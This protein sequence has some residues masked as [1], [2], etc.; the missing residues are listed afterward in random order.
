MFTFRYL[1]T[2]RC[3]HLLLNKTNLPSNQNM[4][5]A[6]RNNKVKLSSWKLK[7]DSCFLY[8][9]IKELCSSF[10]E[11]RLHLQVVKSVLMFLSIPFQNFIISSYSPLTTKH[12]RLR[13]HDQGIG[14]VYYW[15]VPKDEAQNI[16]SCVFRLGL[17]CF[18]LQ[19]S[20]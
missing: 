7:V 4:F 15:W 5:I 10:S 6:K 13:R 14:G 3:V 9:N 12:D 8:T 11:V 18:Q 16:L 1:I 17:L 20:S 2:Y 19:S